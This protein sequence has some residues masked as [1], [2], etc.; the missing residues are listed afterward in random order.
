MSRAIQ[1]RVSESVVRTVHV[2]DGVQSPLELLPVLAPERMAELLAKELE[3]QGFKRDGKLAKR[4]DP[5]GV[6]ITVDL[7]AATVSV[8]L[9]AD[10]PAERGGRAREPHGDREPD[11]RPRRACA[12]PR[13]TS[14]SNASP[15]R[16]KRCAARS[17]TSSRRSSRDLRGELDGSIGRATVGALTERAA[18]ARQDRREF[19][20]DDGR[21]RTIKVEAL[22]QR[23]LAESELPSELSPFQAVDAAYPR[24]A[25][26]LLRRASPPLAGVDRGRER[27]RAVHLSQPARSAEGRWHALPVPRRPRVRGSAAAAARRVAG[28]R[29]DPSDPR[30]RARRGRRAHRRAAAPRHP[31]RERWRGLPRR[32]SARADSAALREPRGAVARLQGSVVPAAAADRRI[33][34]RIANRSWAFPAIGSR[35]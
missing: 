35:I 19:P 9:S 22:T 16:P 2:E 29:D 10:T 33:C 31:R 21:K 4:K 7:E 14:S 26:A 27:A 12:T 28:R 3:A 11:T 6:E 23:V 17:P 5:D 34:F 15:R 13:S 24:R 32:G 20:K 30:G 18:T 1:V 8:K 25:H